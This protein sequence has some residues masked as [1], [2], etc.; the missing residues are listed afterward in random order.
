MNSQV[1]SFGSITSSVQ[2]RVSG[3]AEHLLRK[4]YSDP[5]RLRQ[6][7]DRIWGQ[8]QYKIRVSENFCWVATACRHFRPFFL[9]SLPQ[10]AILTLNLT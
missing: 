1:S 8:N 6:V 5:T 10:F 4:T 3:P 7:L 2:S 9:P